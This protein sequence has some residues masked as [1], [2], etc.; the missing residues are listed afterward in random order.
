M[1]VAI[2]WHFASFQARSAYQAERAAAE[3]GQLTDDRI[4]QNCAGVEA[5]RVLQC[6][7]EQVAATR[8]DQRA[9][10]DLG[11]QERMAEWALWAM[12]SACLTTALSAVAVILLKG[13]LDVTKR[14]VGTANTSNRVAGRAVRQ[15]RR[16]NDIADMAFRIQNRAYVYASEA[17]IIWDGEGAPKIEITVSN[18]GS[19]PASDVTL[20]TQKIVR[21]DSPKPF[22]RNIKRRCHLV[23][24]GSPQS[25][26]LCEVEDLCGDIRKGLQDCLRDRLRVAIVG[27][28]ESTTLYNERVVAPFDFRIV[29]S[30]DID[31]QPMKATETGK[32]AFEI[33]LIDNTEAG[34]EDK[35]ET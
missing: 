4:A 5:S 8:E 17:H 15:A 18:A 25:I 19:T 2:I 29:P 23:E 33:F 1:V 30:N 31:I 7:A 28:V 34:E 21:G 9:E 20:H 3:Y 13:T 6:V 32:P 10:Y 16:A 35:E 22:A 14:A 27:N 24:H 11:A 26:P 12:M